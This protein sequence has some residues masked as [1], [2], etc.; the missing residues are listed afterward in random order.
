MCFQGFTIKRKT[1]VKIRFF[2]FLN[3]KSAYY[4]EHLI[5]FGEYTPWWFTLFRL[6]LPDFNMDN[7]VASSNEDIFTIN[8]IKAFSSICFEILFSTE[9]LDRSKEANIHIHIS[10]LGWFDNTIAID[11][12]LNVARMRAIETSKP[13]IYSVNKSNSAFI[14][15]RGN[16][17]KQQT[18]QGTY[19]I[20]Q[21]IV[22]QQGT[23]FYTKYKNNPLLGTI[24]ILFSIL[25]F[26][27]GKKNK[28][29]E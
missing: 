24:T 16:I 17:L 26:R 18:N 23:T 10:D 11:Y 8:N 14:D 5:P 29:I 2:S 20:N 12:L 13:I 28:I 1:A 22:P 7:L 27:H 21:P 4:K 6:L 25:A 19:L 15:H 3:N 9:I